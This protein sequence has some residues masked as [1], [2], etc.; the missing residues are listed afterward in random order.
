MTNENSGKTPEENPEQDSDESLIAEEDA[1]ASAEQLPDD[2]DESEDLAARNQELI[3][4]V[5][6]LKNERLLALA[7]AEN[8][9]KRADK[10]IADSAKYA[11]SNICKALLQVADNLGR[12]LLATSPQA[13]E[14]NEMLK[15]LAVGVELTAKELTTVLESQGVRR[16]ESLNQAFDANLHNAVQEV[17]NTSVTSGTVVQV[18]Q[19]GYLIHDRL[20]RPAMVVVSRGGPKRV[21]E[22]SDG[23]HEDPDGGSVDTTA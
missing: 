16:V 14:Q 12:A 5:E 3:A 11:V 20:L 17:E 13:R 18:L 9:G 4:L 10:R 2:S 19:D 7:E 8:A 21:T 15:N 6:I 1:E 23:A 22:A